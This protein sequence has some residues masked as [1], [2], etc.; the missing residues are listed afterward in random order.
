MRPVD[1]SEYEA[2][3]ERYLRDELGLADDEP[4]PPPGPVALATAFAHER[5]RPFVEEVGRRMP[6]HREAWSAVMGLARAAGN[7]PERPEV[8]WRDP[9]AR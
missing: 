5:E 6:A 8:V 3:I 4:M 2:V 9:A 1:V 7:G